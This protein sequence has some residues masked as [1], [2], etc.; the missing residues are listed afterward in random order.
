MSK[1]ISGNQ[2]QLLEN[3]E[4]FFP[5]FFEC[6]AAAEHEVVVETF[7][8]FEDKVGKALHAA[9]LKA[10]ARGAQI[11][12]TIDGYGSPDLSAEFIS[13]LVNAGV[14]VHVFEPRRRLW[15]WRTNLFR[16]MHRKI[17]VID[18]QRAFVGGINY[19]ADHLDDFGPLAKQDYAVEI[20]GPIVT[21][22]HQFVR[23]ALAAGQRNAVASFA[24]RLR[25]R[26][27]E[28]ASTLTHTWRH[29]VP[30]PADATGSA[31]AIFVTRDNR[32][33]TNDIERHYRIAIR[34]ARQRIVIA[35]AYF[36]PGYGLLKEMR[37]AARRGVDVRLILQGEPDMAIVKTFGSVLY[38]H[39]MAAG[40]R[41]YEYCERPLHGKV[42]VS[43]N[44]WA[45]VGSSNLDPLSL[46]LNLEA[47]VIIKDRAF[48]QHLSAR[49][50]H[51]MQH[52]CK[53]ISADDLEKP[54][55]WRTLRSFFVFHLLRRYPA[56]AGWLPAHAPRLTPA[57]TP[58][59]APTFTP[60]NPGAAGADTASR[61][62][63]A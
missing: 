43:D 59:I 3:G 60:A 38:P 30:A 33:H 47:N 36:F 2:F 45:T 27:S 48:N 49:L 20:V 28:S 46:S 16:R 15:G 53:Q 32:K 13:A 61:A 7:I 10:A 26:F 8:L 11:D 56:W 29:G 25:E 21:D 23:K 50:N 39:L 63:P 62:D 37:K 24:G 19:S 31:A 17:V 9:L 6:I 12:L 14:R 51:L 55:A 58:T 1:W 57:V 54:S 41:I 40:V 42:A 44:E 4:E 18:G 5:R 52:S 35:N 22:I 34:G